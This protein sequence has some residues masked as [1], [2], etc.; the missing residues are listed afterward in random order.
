MKTIKILLL[1]LFCA[2][3]AYATTAGMVGGDL[4]TATNLDNA[5]T[6]YSGLMSGSFN[7]WNTIVTNSYQPI[8]TSITLTKIKVELNGSPGAGKSYTFDIVKNVTGTPTDSSDD[9]TISGTATTC[10]V[11]ISTALV[12]QDLTAVRCIPSGTPTDRG[13]V[14]YIEYNSATAN[15]TVFL[16]S[17][18]AGEVINTTNTRYCPLAGVCDVDT[19]TGARIK[20]PTTG[21]LKKFTVYSP[22]A[23]DTGAGTQSHTHTITVRPDLSTVSDTSIVVTISEAETIDSD[24]TNTK[25]VT[26]GDSYGAKIV[27]SGTPTAS[28]IAYG[29]VMTMATEGEFVV[30]MAGVLNSAANVYGDPHGN[31]VSFESAR[32]G[33]SGDF[34][35]KSII[36]ETIAAPTSPGTFVLTLR[37][38]SATDTA[39]TV[40]LS[41]A[42]YSEQLTTN[43]TAVALDQ[44]SVKS[45]PASAPGNQTGIIAM[46]G[47]IAPPSG[48]TTNYRYGGT[49]YGGT[50]M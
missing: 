45:V 22:T 27:P 48:A 11:T 17:T 41:N 1:L 42:D 8:P 3:P 34:T 46:L 50:M 24:N 13:A 49:H 36:A 10:E 35:W 40:T 38:N 32:Q 5:A 47:Y 21:T 9:C 12:Q 43:V 30:P 31:F 14:W 39:L 7:A 23:P 26:L 6:A 16:A 25:S 2:I 15:E 18:N 44:W 4:S 28:P 20:M 29:L 37:Q 19:G 33:L